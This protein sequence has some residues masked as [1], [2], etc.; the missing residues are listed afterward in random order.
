MFAAS[1]Q[2]RVFHLIEP[3]NQRT[4]CGLR[5]G[6]FVSAEPKGK[7]LHLI[8]VKPPGSSECKHCSRMNL[9]VRGKS[10]RRDVRVVV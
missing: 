4:I 7:R 8:H 1:A 9:S 5:V 2:S 6:H 10:D 3:N